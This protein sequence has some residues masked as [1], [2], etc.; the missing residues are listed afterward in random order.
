MKKILLVSILTFLSILKGYSMCAPTGYTGLAD[1]LCNGP[2]LTQNGACVNGSTVGVTACANVGCLNEG[3]QDYMEFTA[4]S[5]SVTINLTSTGISDA[6]LALVTTGGS[7]TDHVSDCP[8]PSA[9]CLQNCAT[10]SGT[11]P[12]SLTTS[13]LV[14]GQTYSIIVESVTGGTFSLCV[15]TDPC[16]N[17]IQDG[18]ETGVDCGGGTCPSCPATNDD[19]SDAIDM[20]LDVTEAIG[21][22][23]SNTCTQ[24]LCTDPA[25]EDCYIVDP[26]GAGC[27]LY[28]YMSCG[29]VENNTWYTYTPATTGVYNF[30]L[31][32]QI[33]ANGDGM[34]LWLGTL[35]SACNNNASTYNEIY[36][37]STATPSDINYAATLTAGVTY[38]ITLDGF[39]GDDCTFDF[40]VYG[41]NPLPVKLSYFNGK[42]EN[43]KVVL[44]WVTET[45]INNDYFTIERAKDNLNY[46][47]I[48]TV[49]GAGNSNTTKKYIKE[50]NGLQSGIYYYR[51]RQTD[52]DG[53]SK[54][55]GE[56]VVRISDLAD[57]VLAPN[58]T[59]ADTKIEMFLS[60][61]TYVNITIVDVSGKVVFEEKKELPKGIASYA[62]PSS[63]FAKG[64][65]IVNIHTGDELKTLKL[66]KQ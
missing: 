12:V 17:G 10:S 13:G 27:T 49:I 31:Q 4:T 32:N 22:G 58:V 30:A 26:P 21:S 43:D 37:Q 61:P 52:F 56:I 54:F 2:V 39:A 65:Y 7:C 5:T 23:A 60:K 64:T 11:N 6:D 62:I 40:G 20:T 33:C 42:H 63:D 48:G 28:T 19:C 35:P 36:C 15:I 55:I 47:A 8:T 3:L 1:A 34:Q 53:Q 66:I 46:E 50:D 29:S 18:A 51:L 9:Y 38:Y 24:T 57:F 25:T 59:S 14:I 44:D 41:T 16:G 45:E